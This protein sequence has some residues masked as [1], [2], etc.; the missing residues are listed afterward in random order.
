[1]S[2]NTLNTKY[3]ARSCRR[4]QDLCPFRTTDSR[5]DKKHEFCFLQNRY[6][7]IYIK[8]TSMTPIR[9]SLSTFCQ[10]KIILKQFPIKILEKNVHTCT[11]ILTVILSTSCFRY[12]TLMFYCSYIKIKKIRKRYV[13][14]KANFTFL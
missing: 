4:L 12:K 3:S 10:F 6:C 8:H 5:F 7:Y 1:M 11:C 9:Y 2:Q 14:C 13:Y